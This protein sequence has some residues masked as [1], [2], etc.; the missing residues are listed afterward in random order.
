M[1][2]QETNENP[3]RSNLRPWSQILSR[4]DKGRLMLLT[5]V[6]VYAVFLSL[7][8]STMAT[9]WDEV[10]HLTG[11]LLLIRGDFLQYFLTSSFYPP[12]YNLVTAGY[13]TI[14]GASVFAAR[15]VAVTFSALSVFAIYEISRRMYGSKTALVSAFLFALMPGV[16]W[17]S[18]IALIETM[19]VFVFSVCMLYFF[20]W[21]ETNQERY[22]TVSIVAFVIGG[23]VKYQV[24][25]VVPI[26]MLVSMLI[27]GKRSYLKAQ[28]LRV[29]KFPRLIATIALSAIAAVVIYELYAF[30]LLSV[31]WFAIQTGTAERALS[32]IRFP[33]PVFY[34]VEITSLANG[35]HPVS[36]LF[37]V[38]AL[39]GLAFFGLKRKRQD[40]FLL[41]WF[42]TIYGVFTLI[43]NKEWR[44]VILL[45]PVL[46]I[47][48]SNLIVSVYGKLKG[49][50]KSPKNTI[51][52]K[53]LA[54]LAAVSLAAFT[55]T[56]LFL[57]YSDAQFFLSTA[58]PH[59]PVEEAATFA[60]QTL[61]SNQSLVIACP[62][63]LL[64]NY[65]V[66]FYLNYK[67]SSQITVWQ[68]PAQ[69]ADAYA[70]N[71]NTI[72]FIDMCQQRNVKYVFLYEYDNL[73]YF[74]SSV[75]ASGISAM[76]VASN[77]F[78]VRELFGADSNRIFVFSFE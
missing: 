26:I 77:R 46:A 28:I 23:A 59:L 42:A 58:P 47:S 17:L 34:I 55:V 56:G 8:L 49:T 24:L 53:R 29:L 76:L 36:L 73:N 54:K 57:S 51:L 6:A 41:I 16:V 21:L 25:V 69:A 70:P 78:K 12:I 15:L 63:N 27:F 68:Y 32:S 65:M 72:E 52:K 60:A 10:N 62:T 35:L 44:Y 9:Q 45:F 11:G 33:A 20:M 2:N 66:W 14:L 75:N 13:F 74:D 3:D 71:F 31:I 5:F 18:R 7:N 48:A 64:N 50:W 19:L 39:A 61:G 43:P 38:V 37:Y 4:L 1:K 30:G 40:K 22:L 67:T